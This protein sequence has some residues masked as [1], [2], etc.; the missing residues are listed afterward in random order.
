M[1]TMTMPFS[2][3]MQQ[4]LYGPSGYYMTPRQRFGRAGD[5]FTSAQVSPLFGALWALCALVD[6]EAASVLRIVEVGCGDGGFAEAF[7]HAIMDSPERRGRPV[8][9][10]G[11]DISDVALSRSQQRLAALE[12]TWQLSEPGNLHCVWANSVEQLQTL[13]DESFQGAWIFANEAL[14]AL[15]CEI[16]RI[17]KKTVWRLWVADHQAVPPSALSGSFK[18][19]QLATYFLPLEEEITWR[20]DVRLAFLPMLK[21]S[22]AEV[23]V[24]EW[25]PQLEGWLTSLISTL[26]P[27]ALTFVDYG[28]Y[29]LDVAGDDRPR[30]S[31]RAFRSHQLVEHFLDH[32]GSCDLTYD[33][34]FSIVQHILN[35]R[36]YTVTPLARQGACLLGIEGA[37]QVL[38]QLDEANPGTVRRAL[39]LFMPGGGLGD[40]FVVCRAFAS[41]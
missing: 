22:S 26:S 6:S 9:Y 40:R 19:E 16:I 4:A 21:E 11:I 10:A 2:D 35:A 7:I 17:D 31:L 23:I 28:G 14:D 41:L 32:P 27:S 30:G 36:G 29:T 24:S 13:T 37:E 15:P 8:L 5:F 18:G 1:Q 25:C 20:E 3:Y 39:P 33:V 38:R 34:N 12:R